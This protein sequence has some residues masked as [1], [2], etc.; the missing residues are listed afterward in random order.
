MHRFQK[1]CYVV[2]VFILI[3]A[4][5]AVSSTSSKYINIPE[6]TKKTFLKRHVTC[7]NIDA[8]MPLN[9]I[10]YLF[11]ENYIQ[12]ETTSSSPQHR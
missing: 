8:C 9:L 2:I 5:L 3:A 7:M 11:H 4:Q 12:P 10:L 6:I 1:I